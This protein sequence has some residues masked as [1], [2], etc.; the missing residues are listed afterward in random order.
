M[1]K[2]PR[3]HS[4]F[5]TLFFIVL[6]VHP[7]V[8][9]TSCRITEASAKE[10]ASAPPSENLVLTFSGDIM[11]HDINYLMKDYNKIY[12]DVKELLLSDGLSFA[13]VEMPVC[14]ELPLSSYPSFNVHS[15]YLKAAA[16]A[17]FD[18]FSFANNH[19]NDRQV[20]GIEGTAKSFAALHEAFLQ[21]KGRRLYSSGLKAKKEEDLKPVLIEKNGFKILFL[22]LTEI[23]NSHDSSKGLVYYSEPS[24]AGK[25]ALTEKIRKMRTENPCDLF[26]IS[27]HV[28]EKEY[29]RTVLKAKRNW[30]KAL[31]AAGAD[32]VWA[33]H[34]HVLQGWE[35]VD[36]E[37]ED[38]HINSLFFPQTEE[39][40]NRPPETEKKLPKQP[41]PKPLKFR[42]KAFFMYSMGNFISGQRRR[43]N[44]KN[45]QHYWEYTGD[46][47][48]MQLK[49]PKGA[50]F[51]FANAEVTPVLITAY[52]GTD[53]IVVKRLTPEWASALPEPEKSYYLKR[54]E[55]MKATLPI[56]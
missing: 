41:A 2:T 18:V 37:Y 28:D 35:I 5:Y 48:L 26:V 4:I 14:D 43:P 6:I 13:N 36:I 39:V 32:I 3:F 47:A 24:F 23:L 45:P 40:E 19:T 51:D 29:G 33:N 20:K 55:L 56:E 46:S 54:L 15:D 42:K 16:E 8:C 53:G 11:A 31:A 50:G 10:K 17:G 27:L 1:K 22:A 49:F 52:N 44:Y 25:K 9:Q 7:A 30:F 21:E 34:P 38:E 12:E